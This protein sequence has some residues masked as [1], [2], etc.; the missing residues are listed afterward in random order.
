VRTNIIADAIRPH[1]SMMRAYPPP[2]SHAGEHQVT[3]Y[4]EQHV[5][6]EKDPSAQTVRC[7]AEAEVSIH[8]QGRDC[9]IRA[10]EIVEY[11]QDKQEWKQPNAHLTDCRTRDLTLIIGDR[12]QSRN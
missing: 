6:A 11:V 8:L 5:P 4:F 7:G 3:G 12:A 1:V 9:H 2:R 10:I